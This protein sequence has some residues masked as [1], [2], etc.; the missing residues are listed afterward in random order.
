MVPQRITPLT[1]DSVEE[2]DLEEEDEA[3]DDPMMFDSEKKV[4]YDLEEV[5]EVD[6]SSCEMNHSKPHSGDSVEEYY[7]CYYLKSLK[8]SNS[9]KP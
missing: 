4:M 3:T 2:D 5:E 6:L 9:Q 8:S 1:K 7:V